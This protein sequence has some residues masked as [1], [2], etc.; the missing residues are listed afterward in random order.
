V[1]RPDAPSAHMALGEAHLQKKDYSEAEKSF[2]K[3]LNLRPDLLQAQ[4]AIVATAVA[5]RRYP[6]ALA[7]AREIQKQH[8]KD[9]IGQMLEGD[10]EASRKNIDAAVVAYR[11]SLQKTPS[12]EVAVRLHS[13]L[14]GSNKTA[15]AER[16]AGG[17][18]KDRPKDAVFMFHR[19]DLALYA[20]DLPQAESR[21]RAVL[22]IQPN[23][24]LAMNNVAWLMVQQGK[25]GAL[26]FATKANELLP[27]QPAMLDTLATVYA[28]EKKLPQALEAQK[29]AMTLA[30]QDNGLRLNLAKL[31]VDSGDKAQARIELQLLDKLGTSFP[32]HQKVQE[33]LKSVKS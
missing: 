24:A 5:D 1:V 31:L 10:I 14:I 19:A 17:W 11:A 23:N 32:Q 29:K 2:R 28:A 7:M 12:S 20:R 16:F 18:E 13:L 25:P 3:A 9:G 30:P 26:E 27:N 22:A 33:L 15:D 21:Y 6:D 8:D 4:R